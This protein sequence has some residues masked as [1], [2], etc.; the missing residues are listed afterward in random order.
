MLSDIFV[1][2][3]FG[4]IDPILAIFINENI[5]GGTILTAGIASSL[6]LIT[7]SIIQLPFSR[8][9]DKHGSVNNLKW[10][11]IGTFIVTIVPLVYVFAKDIKIIFF[12]QIIHGIGSALEYPA[13]LWIWSKNLDKGHESFE[14][15]LYSTL[16]SLGTAISAGIGAVIAQFIGFSF[17]FILVSIASLSGCLILINLSKQNKAMI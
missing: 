3:G 4:L 2:T 16:V 7:K 6:F 1:L 9:I 5:I 11:I 8:F 12:A 10:L 15:S 14:W 13:W 17:T